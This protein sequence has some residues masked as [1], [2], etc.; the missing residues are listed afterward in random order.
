MGIAVAVAVG[1]GVGVV[2][3][4][5]VAVAEAV[6][7]R[8]AVAVK[9]AVGE[10]VGV[11][12]TEAVTGQPAVKEA[13][14][15]AKNKAPARV[16]MSDSPFAGGCLGMVKAQVGPSCPDSVPVVWCR[17]TQVLANPGQ[18]NQPHLVR[19]ARATR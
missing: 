15:T 12:R 14:A 10:G 2:V 1:V 5:R 13:R 9:V 16:T 19:R 18:P 6:G 8:V 11:P 4:E 3:G 7:V 17:A